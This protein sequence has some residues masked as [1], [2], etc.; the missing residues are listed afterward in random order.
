MNVVLVMI[1]SVPWSRG[2][3][4]HGPGDRDRAEVMPNLAA[5]GSESFVFERA[6]T[7]L[8]GRIIEG[9]GIEVLSWTTGS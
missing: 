9:V 3:W 6:Y 5:L 8:Y 7:R 1:E 2:P 4:G